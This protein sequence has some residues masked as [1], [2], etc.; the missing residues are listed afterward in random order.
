VHA[1]HNKPE[2]RG[3][4]FTNFSALDEVEIVLSGPLQYIQVTN[5][6]YP[7]QEINITFS[8]LEILEFKKF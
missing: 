3:A 2:I 5:N 6:F 4:S 1:L 8:D 7:D